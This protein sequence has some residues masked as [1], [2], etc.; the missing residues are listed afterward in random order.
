MDVSIILVSYNTKDL[1]RDCIKSVYEKTEGLSYDIWVVDNNSSDGSVEMV[2]E[3]FPDVKLIASKENLG[4][5]RANNAAMRQTNAKY[6]FLLNTDTI[7]LNNAVKILFEFMENPQNADIGACGGQLFNRDMSQQWSVG[8]FDTLEKLYK[9]SIGI[10]FHQIKYR[11][12]DLYSQKT[13]KEN[14][15]RHINSYNTEVDYIIGADLMLRKSALDKAGLFNERFFMFGEEAELQFRLKK[16]G[17]KVKFVKDSRIL[18]YGGASAYN[19]NT[20]VS[21]DRMR[22]QGTILFFE[23]CYGIE[24][25]KKAKLYFIIYYLRYFVLRFF[26]P[27]AFARLKVALELRVPA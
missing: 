18:H 25:A 4:F 20:P 13:N 5:G 16:N 9:K 26:T 2:Q 23:L 11:L 7:L 19:K 24:A 6:C 17:Y 15:K 22:L 1:T 3:E 10:N 27:K 21:V 14:H 12:K 8:E